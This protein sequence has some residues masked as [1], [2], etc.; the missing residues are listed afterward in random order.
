MPLPDKNQP[1]INRLESSRRASSPSSGGNMEDK[2]FFKGR[3]QLARFEIKKSLEKNKAIRTELA[4][5]L[6]LKA[7]SK[8]MD[9]QLKKVQE[10]L[11]ERF[12]GFIDKAEAKR[13]MYEEYWNKKY[14]L[15]EK[16]KDGLTVQEIK[17]MKRREKAGEFLK[18]KLGLGV[19][20][21]TAQHNVFPV[22]QDN[23]AE[24]LPQQTPRG[25][26]ETILPK[27]EVKR[28]SISNE[29]LLKSWIRPKI[30]EE[31]ID[32][33]SQIRPQEEPAIKKEET[34]PKPSKPPRQKKK[35]LWMNR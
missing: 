21:K 25:A 2:S 1:I 11:P 24:N 10:M 12:G 3:S 18:K 34:L 14:D 19:Q 27:I 7:Y 22:R 26:M 8:E 35:P 13:A 30:K 9:A 5:E 29:P 23:H 4:K 32:R 20:K 31:V 17:E 6:K 16:M 28:E 15:R 33:I